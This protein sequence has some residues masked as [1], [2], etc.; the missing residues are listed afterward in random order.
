M[1]YNVS[2]H[3]PRPVGA[4]SSIRAVTHVAARNWGS[5]PVC[6]QGDGSS[7][8]PDQRLLSHRT[9][10]GGS[11]T[12]IEWVPSGIHR[13]SSPV[14][15]LLGPIWMTCTVKHPTPFAVRTTRPLVHS[16]P[17]QQA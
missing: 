4:V 10:R 3:C 6:W 2:D 11:R 13:V 8:T 16:I 17:G 14:S 9:R 12:G 5:S 1:M 7:S 15:I